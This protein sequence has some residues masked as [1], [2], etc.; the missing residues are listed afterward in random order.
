MLHEALANY[1]DGVEQAIL[2][3]NNAYVERYTEEIV[4]SNRINLRIRIRFEQRL[5]LEIKGL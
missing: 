1:L 5:L 4:E 3:C 2:R